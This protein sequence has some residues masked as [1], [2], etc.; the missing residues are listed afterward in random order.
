[1]ENIFLRPERPGDF[2]FVENLTREAFWDVYQPG[3]DEH[4]ILHKLRSDPA[5]LPD[6]D[7]VA[8]SQG[9]IVGHIVYSLARITEET[10][11]DHP[12]VIFGPI[13]VDPC[14]QGRGIGSALIRHTIALAKSQGFPAIVIYGNPAYYH[15]FGFRDA[16]DFGITTAD[17]ANFEAFM[18]L[19]LDPDV[20]RTIHGKFHE[21]PVFFA[22]P[23]ELAAYETRF[24]PKEKHVTDT[25]LR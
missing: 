21:S 19:E 17:G 6:L 5:F 23:D 8:E 4:F 20:L 18:V 13:S 1:M 24:P 25:Q 2:D 14:L 16:K 11:I 10:G 9:K 12:V 3:C 22:D 7:F 15:R